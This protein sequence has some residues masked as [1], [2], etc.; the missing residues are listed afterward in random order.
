[1]ASLEEDI[2][3]MSDW[4]V[5]A[6][7]ADKLLLDYTPASFRRID[8]FFE[9]HSA[10]GNAKPKGRLS[11]NR[12]PILFA[13]GSYVGETII[14]NVPGS[15]WRTNDADP[16]GEI[17]A[18]IVLP[19]GTVLWPMQRVIKRFKNGA[20]DGIYAY[21]AVVIKEMGA[22]DY[23]EKLE[24]KRVAGKIAGKKPWWKLW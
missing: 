13:I 4:I 1:M 2:K 11:T 15:V 3:K 24:D 18:E 23:W 6:F 7:K 8:D 21:G 10:G 22:G 9:K 19:D 12:G 14:R 20:E 5:G 17:N 16:E